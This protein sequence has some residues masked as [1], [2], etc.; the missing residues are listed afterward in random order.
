MRKLLAG[1]LICGTLL[2]TNPVHAF[3]KNIGDVVMIVGGCLELKDIKPLLEVLASKDAA[4]IDEYL[5]SDTNS[6]SIIDPT[7]LKIVEYLETFTNV[8]GKN[9][10]IYKL[11]STKGQYIYG[12]Y[13]L[14]EDPA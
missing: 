6:C 3:E 13:V 11:K 1:L 9:I 14:H 4:K 10:E 8:D 2:F 7:P 12:F 5:E